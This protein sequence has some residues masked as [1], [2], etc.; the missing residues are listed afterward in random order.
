MDVDLIAEVTSSIVAMGELSP[1]Q[2]ITFSSLA[3]LNKNW[4]DYKSAEPL[5]KDDKVRKAVRAWA[6]S[7]N[8]PSE[9]TVFYNDDEYSLGWYHCEIMFPKRI[10][11]L[12]EKEYTIAELC[13]EEE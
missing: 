2:F 8:L 11:G 7:V 1:R 5:I 12:K 6:E 10:Q 13:G 9:E 3:E 4:E